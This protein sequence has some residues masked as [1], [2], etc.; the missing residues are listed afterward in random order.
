MSGVI[1]SEAR[2]AFIRLLQLP[3]AELDLAEGALLIA[4]E[5]YS[6]LRPSAYLERLLR[7]AAELKRRIK[8]EVKPSRVVE[9]C[10]EYFFEELNFKGNRQEYYDPRNSYLNDVIERR[11]G[12]PITLSVIYLAVGE[13]A[14]LPVRGVGMPGHFLVK[15]APAA[16]DSEIFIDPFNGRTLDRQECAK[17]LQ[18]MYG[19]AV[20]M[21]PSFLEP[22]G[23]RQIL[24][25]ILNNLK[26]LYLSRGDLVRALAAS[27]RILLADPHLTAEWRDRGLIYF[28]MHRDTEALK[29]FSRYLDIKPEPE[30]SPR[31][32][33]MRNELLSRLN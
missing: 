31:I 17:M 25:R 27:E 10:N 12:I 6:D 9:I 5:E 32:K 24:A 23:K 28:Q 1:Q 4:A 18:E 26:G 19:E 15:Y 14:G 13:R 8:T 30:D 11:I 16:T 21:K 3:D 2:A 20:E 29:D 33:Q 22:T 7:M